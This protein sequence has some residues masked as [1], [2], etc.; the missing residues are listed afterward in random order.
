MS[1][2]AHIK[3]IGHSSVPLLVIGLHTF[4][5]RQCLTVPHHGSTSSCCRANRIVSPWLSIICHSGIRVRD[6]VMRP[7]LLL[8]MLIAADTRRVSRRVQR[9][10]SL[11]H[12]I[13]DRSLLLRLLLLCWPADA[14]QGAKCPR[15]IVFSVSLF[16]FESLFDLF[17]A[18][19]GSIVD[20]DPPCSLPPRHVPVRHFVAFIHYSIVFFFL[21]LFNA[22]F[23]CCHHFLSPM[24]FLGLNF[25]FFFS[26]LLSPC[27]F[28]LSCL[29]SSRPAPFAFS[30]VLLLLLSL[31]A[32]FLPFALNP[33]VLH[34]CS[35]SFFPFVSLL[36]S[37][38]LSP[39][40]LIPFLRRRHSLPV[41]SFASLPFLLLSLGLIWPRG[42]SHRPPC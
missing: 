11:D 25:S 4:H 19:L 5:F 1:G 28:L 38:L 21:F 8:Q 6:A 31:R 39:V 2:S 37:L 32:C 22:F 17:C 27:F 3:G 35:V 42:V 13:E 16:S 18:V 36:R 26:L 15:C 12:C 7:R 9:Q 34:S 10:N 24:P 14:A 41:S 40:L 30:S 20:S 29:L 33:V 23:L